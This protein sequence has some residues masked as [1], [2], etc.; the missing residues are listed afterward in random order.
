MLN[1]GDILD[2]KYR[3]I[4]LLGKG[5]MGYVYLAENIKIGNRW[6]IKEI[7]ISKKLRTDL[8]AESEILKKLNHRSLPR[9]VDII[10]FESFLYIVEDYFEGI[11]LKELIKSREIC[12]ENN[13]INWARQLCEILSYLHS[14]KPNPIIYR[15]M[16]PGNIIIDSNLNV[17]LIDLGIAREYKA[18]QESDTLYIGTRGYAAPEQ[19]SGAG[20]T[21]ERTDIYGLGATLYHA[22]T[23]VN[24]KDP[25]FQMLPVT[26]V[27]KSL[28]NEIEKIITKCIQHNPALRYQSVD[29]LLEDLNDISKFKEV[30]ILDTSQ[31]KEAPC[32]LIIIGSL[33]PRAGSS[34]I[35]ANLA[36][37]VAA[38]D[39][40][41]AV[42]EA[43]VN[44]P[45]YY[46][47][48]F[49]RKKTSVNFVSWPH[50]IKKGNSINRHDVFKEEGINWIVLDPTLLSIKD[51]SCDDMMKLIYSV[52]RIPVV[53]LD[54]ST[55]WVHQ[56]VQFILTQAD[57]I[58][59][60][61][62]PDPVLID[63][64]AS[65]DQT[66]LC[67][68]EECL[69]L[70]IKIVQLLTKLVCEEYCDVNLIINKYPEFIDKSQL[71]LPFKPIAF[72]PHMNP[73]E[74]YKALWE[75]S[76]LY[77]YPE[78]KEVLDAKLSPVIERL[79]PLGINSGSQ[80]QKESFFQRMRAAYKLLIGNKGDLL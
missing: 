37:A 8:L 10:E 39:I 70:E 27:N 19:Y 23:G 28:S 66:E 56:S 57:H 31:Y 1:I 11:C 2:G 34:F 16:K 78:A 58:F 73:S 4:D 25:P 18:D 24:P 17:K 26:Q 30:E 44:T 55:N 20:Q 5:G 52:K 45:Y 75:G 76:L 62:D 59:L 79:V 53:F 3:L 60:V 49:I 9:I 74:V 63:R 61:V 80:K 33:S 47:A 21:D 6:A 12:H 32:K 22:I 43:P 64:T 48:L 40:L 7:D 50:E 36:A 72:F 35:T 77:K 51:W 67:I 68:S 71:C 13:V 69:P 54:V 42:I 29:E 41:T 65:V 46:D 38:K 14:F 15:D